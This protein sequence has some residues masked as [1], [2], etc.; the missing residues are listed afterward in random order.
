MEEDKQQENIQFNAA[1]CAFAGVSFHK[2]GGL[3]QPIVYLPEEKVNK[4]AFAGILVQAISE[5]ADMD[6]FALFHRAS[7]VRRLRMEHSKEE[8]ET[9]EKVKE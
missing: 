2:D 4:E 1:F 8:T 7:E 9:E 6:L 3:R 5:A